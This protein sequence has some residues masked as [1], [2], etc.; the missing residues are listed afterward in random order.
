MAVGLILLS[1]VSILVL[2]G[3]AQRVL[4]RM[5]LSDRAALIIAAAIFFGGLAP[6]IRIGMVSVNL[7]GALIPL[8]LCVYLFIKAD[9]FSLRDFGGVSTIRNTSTS[10]LPGLVISIRFENI[11]TVGPVPVMEKS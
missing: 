3:V 8:A 6:D 4:D 11:S 7:G 1:A 2:L 9:S 5:Q 10:G